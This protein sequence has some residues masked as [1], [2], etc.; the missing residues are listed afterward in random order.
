MTPLAVVLDFA[1]GY[2]EFTG[3]YNGYVSASRLAVTAGISF[4]LMA[5]MIVAGIYIPARKAMKID[6]AIAL[7]D[8]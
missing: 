2:F 5:L 8:E 4:L 1:I 6:P 3:W 7:K